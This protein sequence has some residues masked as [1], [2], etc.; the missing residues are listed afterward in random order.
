MKDIYIMPTQHFDLIW[1]KSGE[2]YRSVRTR[3]IKKSLEIMK[4]HPEYRFYLDEAE[5]I[6]EFMEQNPEYADELTNAIKS[7]K[8]AICGGGWSLADTNMVCGES[9]VRNLMYGRQWFKKTFGIDVAS[10]SYVDSFGMCGQLPQIMKKLGD[11]FCVPGRTPGGEGKY[12]YGDYG[13]FR[14]KGIDGT[15]VISGISALGQMSWDGMSGFDGYGVMEGF[16]DLYRQKG[17]DR[18]L[19]KKNITAGLEDLTKVRGDVLFTEYT[20]EEHTPSDV[21]PQIV[22]NLN[23]KSGSCNFHIC[24][25]DEFFSQVKRSRLPVICGE[26]NPVFTGCYTTRIKI[27]QEIRK[28]ENALLSEESLLVLSRILSGKKLSDHL[29]EAWR[30]FSYAEFHDA[31]CGCHIDESSR[32]IFAKINNVLTHAKERYTFAQLAAD[33]LQAPQNSYAVFNTLGFSREDTAVLSG[34][35]NFGIMDDKGNLVPSVDEEDGIHFAASLPAFGYRCYRAV[36][37]SQGTASHKLKS[38]CFETARYQV[39][40]SPR[41]LFIFDKLLGTRLDTEAMPLGNI[42]FA[43]DSG[44]LWVER[45]TGKQDDESC[46][47]IQLVSKEEN[48]V[49]LRVTYRGEIS[50]DDLKEKWDGAETLFWQKKYTFYRN[51][52]CIDLNVRIE[53]SGKNSTVFTQYPCKFVS[54]G[55]KALY[56]VP[57]GSQKRAPYAADY[58][59]N[60][61]GSW[62]ALN[63]ADFSDSSCGLAVANSGTPSYRIEDKKIQVTLLRS[64]S[65]WSAPAFP[66]APEEGS[67]DG[68]RHEFEFAVLPHRNDWLESKAY[69]LG[70]KLNRRPEVSK[71]NQTGTALPTAY[72]LFRISNP[73]IILS[74]CKPAENDDAVTIRLYE[75]TG[76][77]SLTKVESAVEIQRAV[78]TDMGEIREIGDIDLSSLEFQPYEI[79]TIKLYL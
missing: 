7:G 59:K 50:Q 43:E 63:S 4:K 5:V 9:I 6:S 54:D 11:N 53:W 35:H 79:K 41:R 72:S 56:E 25:P 71:I 22:E 36:Q 55:G 66:F 52:D 34:V 33:S 32:E 47:R 13:C 70:M 77:R 42:V 1:R 40:I 38:N 44:N 68:G 58:E 19:A 3:V 2:Y 23:A 78:E 27:K 60:K 28:A 39:Q 12:E 51:L 62:P 64:G 49:F 15:E 29:S 30:D 74:A 20:G 14:W 45:L 46:G 24:T 37:G 26:F 75:F 48:S 17:D 61:G 73:N 76:K 8:F 21:L 67:F 16:D 57:F 18:G 69:Q 65:D 10:G 31:I